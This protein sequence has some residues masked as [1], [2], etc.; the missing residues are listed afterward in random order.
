MCV[1]E[2][3]EREPWR[4]GGEQVI[5]IC[6]FPT[7]SSVYSEVAAAAKATRQSLNF[8]CL[9]CSPRILVLPFEES[10]GDEIRQ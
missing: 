4:Q 3:R 9:I 1:K 5:E 10:G 6:L 2:K 8:S 7:T